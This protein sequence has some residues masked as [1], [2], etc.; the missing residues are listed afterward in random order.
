MKRRYRSLDQIIT[1][2]WLAGWAGCLCR[3]PD[4][5]KHLDRKNQIITVARLRRN[6][7]YHTPLII[8]TSVSL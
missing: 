1:L 7:D 2:A 6:Q 8:L 4:S 5:N 3:Q